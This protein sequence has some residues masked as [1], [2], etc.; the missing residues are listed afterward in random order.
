MVSIRLAEMQDFEAFY[1]IKCEPSNIF[2]AGFN[3]PPMKERLLEWFKDKISRQANHLS[4][5][6]YMISDNN[7][8]PT[9]NYRIYIHRPSD[10]ER[11]RNFNCNFR[12]FLGLPLCAYRL[13]ADRGSCQS[14]GIFSNCR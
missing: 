12:V 8:P 7:T 11:M 5:K 10:T 9:T 13:E 3:A 1:Q 2:W 4:R 6:I 14:M